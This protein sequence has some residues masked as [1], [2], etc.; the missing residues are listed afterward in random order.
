[1]WSFRRFRAHGITCCGNIVSEEGK[2]ITSGHLSA[3]PIVEKIKGR[4][5]K[6]GRFR[7]RRERERWVELYE[8]GVIESIVLSPRRDGKSCS[9]QWRPHGQDWGGSCRLLHACAR[10]YLALLWEST[11][12]LFG[13]V[14]SKI[15]SEKRG[16]CHTVFWTDFSLAAGSQWH[17][18]TLGFL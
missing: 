4:L 13:K 3:V 15:Q 16:L 2:C 7:Y 14:R 11:V 10:T 18:S 6:A 8:R 5:Q 12:A 17:D 9:V 1:M